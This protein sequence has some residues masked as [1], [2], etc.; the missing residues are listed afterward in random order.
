MRE[1]GLREPPAW[2][3]S[4]DEEDYFIQTGTLP[5]ALA[6]TSANVDLNGVRVPV[7]QDDGSYKDAEGRVMQR[8]DMADYF[9]RLRRANAAAAATEAMEEEDDDDDEYDYDG[10][11]G[12]AASVLGPNRL[13]V[14]NLSL[15][16]KLRKE[17]NCITK[18]SN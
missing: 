2:Y 7:R 3:A 5:K 9:D 11:E 16:G 15:L 18:K 13:V 1:Q 4:Q 6:A 10:E 12:A 17:L 8:E 14:K